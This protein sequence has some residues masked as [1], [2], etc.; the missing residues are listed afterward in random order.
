MNYSVE[1]MHLIFPMTH[2]ACD[3]RLTA[4]P[5]KRGRKH[6][7]LR[8]HIYTHHLAKRIRFSLYSSLHYYPLCQTNSL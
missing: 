8:G 5:P 3:T 2:L 6:A 4:M 7:Y 1:D